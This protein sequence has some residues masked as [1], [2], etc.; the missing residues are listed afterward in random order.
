MTIDT[1]ILIAYGA[2]YVKAKKGDEIFS[3]GTIARCFYQI[4][5]GEIKMSSMN[6]DGKEMIQGVFKSGDSFGEPPLFIDRAYPSTAIATI[7]SI[8]IKLSKETFFKILLDYPHL[9]QSLLITF[10]SRIYH[11]ASTVQILNYHTPEEK[12]L[13][14]LDKLKEESIEKEKPILIPFT[15]QQLAEFT[16]L[17]VETVIRTLSKLNES[18]K[19]EIINHK[20]YY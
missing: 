11:K 2:T 15:R 10:A 12:I 20:V 13:G 1:D 14:F 4:I 3:E 9:A 18:K 5:D 19:V 8:I 17:R 6:F 7:D 16:G